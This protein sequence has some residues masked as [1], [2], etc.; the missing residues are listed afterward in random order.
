MNP[1]KPPGKSPAKTRKKGP[2]PTGPDPKDALQQ[3]EA[4][5]HGLFNTVRQAIYIQ[6]NEGRFVDVNDGACA[7]YGY[8]RG[9]FI[10]RTPEFLS[11][12]GLNDFEFVSEKIRQA[13]DGEPQQFE[14]WAKRTGM[15]SPW[16]SISAK[17]PVSG[18]TS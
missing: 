7:M 14:F 11:A 12:P 2:A 8:G 4:G 9:E 6:D 18:K 15:S 5:Y 16:R 13:F 10:G 3:S 1:G 17:V